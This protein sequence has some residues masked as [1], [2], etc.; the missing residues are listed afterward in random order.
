MAPRL[1]AG[2][3]AYVRPLDADIELV[4]DAST[5]EAFK[6][7]EVQRWLLFDANEVCIGR[8]AAFTDSRKMDE[9]VKPGGMGFFECI[10]D[11]IAANALLHA[12]E[13]WLQ[14]RGANAVDGP[15]NFGDRDRWWG[16]LVDGFTRPSYGCAYNPPYYRN[17]LE[18]NG[19]Q[20]YFEQYTYHRPVLKPL[21][22]IIHARAR[23]VLA[24]PDYSFKHIHLKDVALHTEEFRTIYNK[25]WAHHTGI[26]EMGP[27]LAKKLVDQLKDVF[28]PKLIWFAYHLDEPVAF[29]VSLP[30]INQII[31]RMNGKF[32]LW[33]KLLFWYY[34]RFV[35]L[36]R[37][38]GLVFGVVPE[39]QSK[40]VES[41]IILESAK[42]LHD[43]SQVKYR[44]FE[45]NWIGDFN[46]AM[47]KLCQLLG[48][49]VNKVQITYRKMLDPTV[50]F[51]R[52]P[53]IVR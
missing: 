25:A 39:Q 16:L 12:A 33:Q 30:D 13:Q 24:N 35:Q 50:P 10:D 29:F 53:M 6:Y 51:E 18:A 34:K 31:A 38:F 21:H 49:E 19:Y 23:R 48:C 47:M 26:P 45:M 15:I 22:P 8:V 52:M 1:Y 4:F 3:P 17:L 40:G 2:D 46:P 20:T 36:N 28:D 43:T 9:E 44:E 37:M 41:A 7:G 11:I 5:N 14:T 27:A 42:V 32:G